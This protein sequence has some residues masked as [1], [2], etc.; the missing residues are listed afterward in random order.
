MIATLGEMSTVAAEATP[1]LAELMDDKHP[2]VRIETVKALAQL[3]PAARPAA[4]NQ[5][6]GRDQEA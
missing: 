1:V 4:A 3:G 6:R 2:Y 5:G